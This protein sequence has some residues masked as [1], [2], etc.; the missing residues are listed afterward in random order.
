M[1]TQKIYLTLKAYVPGDFV[2]RGKGK[3]PEW[4]KI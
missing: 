3:Q 2:E 1:K 4:I